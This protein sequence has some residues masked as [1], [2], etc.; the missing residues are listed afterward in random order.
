M[1]RYLLWVMLWGWESESRG[2]RCGVGV[3]G[4]GWVVMVIVKWYGCSFGG[5]ACGDHVGGVEAYSLG[6]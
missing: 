5:V 4:C 6:D 3:W 2:G 1:L